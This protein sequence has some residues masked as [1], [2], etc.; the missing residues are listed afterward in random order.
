MK[1]TTF[2]IVVLLSAVLCIYALAGD[3][4]VLKVGPITGTSAEC[5]AGFEVY[6]PTQDVVLRGIWVNFPSAQTGTLELLKDSAEG[7]AEDGDIVDVT[8]TANKKY[9]RSFGRDG[10]RLVGKT[11]TYITKDAFDIRMTAASDEVTVTT[12]WEPLNN[13]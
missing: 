4:K 8:F 7:T 3:F 1:T 13:H 9:F 2:F 10:V 6:A 5:R 12:E 11:G